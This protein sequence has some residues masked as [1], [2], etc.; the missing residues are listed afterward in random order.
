MRVGQKHHHLVFQRNEIAKYA[1]EAA[2]TKNNG[3]TYGI[4]NELWKVADKLRGHFE[5][6]EVTAIFS[7]RITFC[8]F[9][10]HFAITAL[11]EDGIRNCQGENGI[12]RKGGTFLEQSEA[13]IPANVMLKAEADH[14]ASN[15]AEKDGKGYQVQPL[16]KMFF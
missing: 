9:H 7:T 11:I 1:K 14:V 12:I 13:R 5:A 8:V 4:K 3:A 10:N 16:R 2:K 6:A 15:G